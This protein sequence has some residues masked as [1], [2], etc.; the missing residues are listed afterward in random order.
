MKKDKELESLFREEAGR[1]VRDSSGWHISDSAEFVARLSA[2]LDA[3]DAGR[4][5]SRGLSDYYSAVVK[6]VERSDGHTLVRRAVVFACSLAGML[7]FVLTGGMN[8]ILS[9]LPSAETLLRTLPR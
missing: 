7:I 3:E 6:Q 4:A 5:K 2:R 8:A 9:L 1:Q